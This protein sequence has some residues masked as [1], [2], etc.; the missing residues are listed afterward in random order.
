MH[1]VRLKDEMRL[2]LA[3]VVEA[4]RAKYIWRS[5]SLFIMVGNE[6]VMVQSFTNVVRDVPLPPNP[7]PSIIHTHRPYLPIPDIQ[8]STYICTPPHRQTDRQCC[9]KTVTYFWSMCIHYKVFTQMF[10]SVKYVFPLG[11][12]KNNIFHL[13]E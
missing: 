1:H 5:L 11:L 12:Y 3:D 4:R 2:V 9:H 7:E 10:V 8:Y 13:Q 6:L